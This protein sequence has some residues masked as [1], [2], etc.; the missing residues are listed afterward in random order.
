MNATVNGERR[1]IS[2]GTTIADLLGGLNIDRAGIA[3]AVNERIVRRA[4][5]EEHALCDGDAVEII[6]AVAGG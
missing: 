5:F 2:E 4:A 6:R 3:V 1:A